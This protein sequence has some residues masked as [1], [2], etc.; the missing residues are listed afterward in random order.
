MVRNMDTNDAVIVIDSREKLPYSIDLPS[1]T[2]KLEAGDYSVEGLERRVAVERKSL[3][4]FVST[5][6]WD[7]D[8]FFK[9]LRKLAEYD[10]A[11]VVVEA[12]LTDI[13]QGRYRSEAHPRSVLGMTLSIIADFEV[14]VFFCSNRRISRQFVTSLLLRLHR[15]YFDCGISE[16]GKA[17]HENQ[18]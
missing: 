9:E 8:R 17:D 7:R 10:F 1:I 3:D 12:D 18:G 4:D 5:V 15:K 13:V 11:C 2:K 14:P 6:I 16:M